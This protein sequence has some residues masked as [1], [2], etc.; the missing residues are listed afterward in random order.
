MRPISAGW[1]GSAFT[2]VTALLMSARRKALKARRT[3]GI[4]M[5]MT[6]ITAAN[7]IAA[8]IL[9]GTAGALVLVRH[10]TLPLLPSAAYGLPPAAGLA[11]SALFLCITRGLLQGTGFFEVPRLL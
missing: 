9:F 10:S 8:P 6:T 1:V 2:N 7:P 11:L 5:P 3:S 4:K